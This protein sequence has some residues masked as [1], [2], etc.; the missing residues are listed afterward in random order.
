[1]IK[2]KGADINHTQ[3]CTGT[4]CVYLCDRLCVDITKVERNSY[5]IQVL[6]DFLEKEEGG[7]KISKGDTVG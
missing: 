7:K 2:I 5:Y 1:M 3:I 4:W 6:K